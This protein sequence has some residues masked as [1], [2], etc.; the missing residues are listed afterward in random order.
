MSV[1]HRLDV[2]PRVLVIDDLMG[3]DQPTKIH[4]QSRADYCRALG[5]RD[6]GTKVEPGHA[7]VADAF[8][9]SGHRVTGTAP[10]NSIE[11]VEEVF[12]AGWPAPLGRYW[13]AALVDLKFG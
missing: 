11:L 7:I 4:L 12:R 8:I 2:R 6:E 3:M 5:L 1:R 10:V 13:S 9:S